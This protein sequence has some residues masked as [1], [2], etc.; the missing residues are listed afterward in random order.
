MSKE[1]RLIIILLFIYNVV[2]SQVGIN[3]N[4]PKETVHVAGANETVRVDGLNEVNNV[5]N[6]GNGMTTRVY[7]DRNGDLVL[8]AASETLDILVDYE[9]YLEDVENDTN[10]IDQANDAIGYT[11]A[12]IPIDGLTASFT[13]EKTAM[14][15]VNYSV[16]WS[17]YKTEGSNIG[18]VEDE[19]IR[20][21]QTGVYFRKGDYLGE[22]ITYD[23]NGIAINDGPWCIKMDSSGN[24]CQEQGGLL[25]INGQFYNNAENNNGEYENFHNTGS[26]Y[27]KLGPGTY[28]VMFSAQL[29]VEDSGG[30][31]DVR[32]YLGSGKDDLQVIAHYY[33]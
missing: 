24:N 23:A 8:G 27:V 12:G 11:T 20:I 32:M 10:R 28:C 26:D 18:R 16:S 22:A 4:Y 3:T 14:V 25:A 5:N 9:N 33:N 6:L 31:G 7:V 30:T 15:E 19:H 17:I 2:S 13:L 1:I 29:Q 21:V